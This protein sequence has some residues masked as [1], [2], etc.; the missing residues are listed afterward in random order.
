[1][2]KVE[3]FELRKKMDALTHD[4]RKQIEERLKLVM[5]GRMIL[6]ISY[7]LIYLSV[8]SIHLFVCICLSVSLSLSTS[9]SKSRR[10]SSFL[11]K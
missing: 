5:A 2:T 8:L 9:V 4:E 11:W 10:D 3:R 1:M 7:F 6:F